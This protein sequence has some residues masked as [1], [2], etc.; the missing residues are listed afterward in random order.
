MLLFLWFSINLS[1][2][3]DFNMGGGGESKIATNTD[4]KTGSKSSPTLIIRVNLII[5]YLF[6]HIN[7]F[8]PYFAEV[9]PTDS[10]LWFFHWFR[11]FLCHPFSYQKISQFNDC[12]LSSFAVSIFYNFMVLGW[13][14]W[15]N[16]FLNLLHP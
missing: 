15:T 9:S 3:I 2:C 13:L 6:V 7:A 5:Y 8:S 12:V 4:S 16:S 10:P 14:R 1:G 11:I